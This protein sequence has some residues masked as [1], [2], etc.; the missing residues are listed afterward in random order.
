MAHGSVSVAVAEAQVVVELQACLAQ[1]T[2]AAVVAEAQ[3]LV[4]LLRLVV[5]AAVQ[6]A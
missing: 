3:A 1:R 2:Q 5:A 6:V 4:V